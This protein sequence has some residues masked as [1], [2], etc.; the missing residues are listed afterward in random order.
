MS[1]VIMAKT[2]LMKL[3]QK[4]KLK[5]VVFSIFFFISLGVLSMPE[6]NRFPVFQG[7]IELPAASADE[8]Y[9]ILGQ[10]APDL[11]LNT[12]IDENGKETEPISLNDYRGKIVYLY[13][14]Q[15][16]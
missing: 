7:M 10:P 11:E 1:I 15:D 5:H 2:F 3:I 14:F 13:F 4:H 9:G 12:W 8:E 6:M 16:G